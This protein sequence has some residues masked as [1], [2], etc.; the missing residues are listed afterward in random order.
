M[1]TSLTRIIIAGALATTA[2]LQGASAECTAPAKPVPTKPAS[3]KPSPNDPA[4]LSASF[5][6]T[7][8]KTEASESF[9]ALKAAIARPPAT[10][11]TGNANTQRIIDV[12]VTKPADVAKV[13]SDATAAS[14]DAASTQALSTVVNMITSPKTREEA[15]ALVAPDAQARVETWRANLSTGV[16]GLPGIYLGDNAVASGGERQPAPAGYTPVSG[17]SAGCPTR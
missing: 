11:P 1:A 15:A 5:W 17:G 4:T 13:M 2:T 14:Q 9:A 3:A 10:T 16:E 7:T 12:A 6:T 8:R